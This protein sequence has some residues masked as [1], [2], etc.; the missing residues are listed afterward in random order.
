VLAF[1][2]KLHPSIRN[3]HVIRL[4]AFTVV[5]VGLFVHT[6]L[7][8]T[9]DQVAA[10][11][12]Y[13]IDYDTGAVLL[14]KGGNDK[15]PTSSMSKVM[16]MY[17][18][19][20]AL[21]NGRIK[22]DDKFTVSEKA[23]RMQG[24]KMFVPIG[25]QIP[26]EDLIRGV[27]IQSGNDATIVLAEGLAG[28]E[29]AF[30]DAMNAKAQELGM[31][32][33][34]F[35]NASGWPD[36]DHYSTPHDLVVMTKALISRFPQYYKYYSEK[37]FTYNKIKQGNRNP[38]LYKNLGADGVKTGHAEE[39]GY[40]LIGSGVR[41]GR[42]VIFVINGAKDMQTRADVSE[43]I[44]DWALG[45]FDNLSPYAGGKTVTTARVV[46]GDR[47]QVPLV[48]GRTFNVTVPK[49]STASVKMTAQ[50]KEP[51]VAP[52]KA[53]T[54]VGNVTVVLGDGEPAVLPLVVAQDVGQMDLFSRTIAKA[55]YVLTGKDF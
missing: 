35:K 14:D 30:V 51:L 6:A 27:I 25:D 37:E 7:A 3:P 11:E 55:L 21:E 39:A 18:V 10:K 53:G 38:L 29:G 1:V 4:F 34:N 12:A 33:S 42:R 46:L 49:L 26:V 8:L 20:E 2:F 45:S 15:M 24:S 50:F 47:A 40:G 28:S 17:M 13:V 44:L 41:N 52:V 9:A 22:Q 32:D 23:W 54:E 48:L 16:T 19:F 31:K 36:P 5:F 43:K